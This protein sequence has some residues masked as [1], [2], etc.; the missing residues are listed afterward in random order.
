MAL[1][2]AFVLV[3]S[4][5]C[6]SR[7]VILVSM[8]CM[9][10]GIGGSASGTEV[11]AEPQWGISRQSLDTRTRQDNQSDHAKHIQKKAP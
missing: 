5:V 8:L 1:T 11:A 9:G 10:M 7:M 4:F 6:D 3:P 2:Q